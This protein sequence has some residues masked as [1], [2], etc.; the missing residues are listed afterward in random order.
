M[1]ADI[2]GPKIGSLKQFE[3]VQRCSWLSKDP[4]DPCDHVV[5]YDT[6]WEGSGNILS[7]SG[8]PTEA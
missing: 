5:H 4:N 7:P 1:K 8:N 2:E 3:A 6:L